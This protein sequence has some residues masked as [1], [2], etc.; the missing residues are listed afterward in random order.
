MKITKGNF[1]ALLKEGKSI[2]EIIDADLSLIS[3][4]DTEDKETTN[5]A[6]TNSFTDAAAQQIG[7]NRYYG[8][9]L[10]EDDL[11]EENSKLKDK[12]YSFPDEI[13]EV[14]RGKLS[15]DEGVERIKGI[16][17]DNRMT[18]HQI[19]RF[20]HDIEKEYKG[21]W[22]AVLGWINSVLTTD[23]DSIQRNKQVTHDTGMENRF[24]KNH[25]KS[26][27]K[28][29]QLNENFNDYK[30]SALREM[31]KKK[32]EELKELRSEIKE[33][34]AIVSKRVKNNLDEKKK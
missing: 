27:V 18:Y 9:F 6:T 32:K 22:S 11:N 3:G 25:E 30:V 33:I 5:K 34:E 4:T 14:L 15:G 31:L 8:T 28:P 13:L 1:L 19:K 23:R 20:K 29:T 24:I 26:Y 12:V 2:D 7:K 17:A 21:D 10:E 16:L